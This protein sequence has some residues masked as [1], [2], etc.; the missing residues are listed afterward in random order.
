MLAVND[1]TLQKKFAEYCDEVT[2]N[3]ETLIVTR[4]NEK[5]FVMIPIEDWNSLQ[6]SARNEEYLRKLDRSIAQIREGRVV[7]KTMEELEAMAD[8]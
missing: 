7:V 6:K 8:E 1:V 5:S 3:H 2:S 4:E